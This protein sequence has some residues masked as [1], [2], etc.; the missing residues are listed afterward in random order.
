[1]KRSAEAEHQAAA[2]EPQVWIE[3]CDLFGQPVGEQ[4]QPAGLEEISGSAEPAAPSNESDLFTYVPPAPPAM[5]AIRAAVEPENIG[6]IDLFG[7]VVEEDAP[8]RQASGA[9]DAGKTAPPP[10]GPDLFDFANRAPEPATAEAQPLDSDDFF[11]SV[12][13]Q[14]EEIQLPQTLHEALP[15]Q[16]AAEEAFEPAATPQTA[17]RSPQAEAAEDALRA[18]LPQLDEASKPAA[19]TSLLRSTSWL[20]HLLPRLTPIYS[21]IYKNLA[22]VI[23]GALFTAFVS[24]GVMITFFLTSN[25]WSA[26]IT[27]SRGHELVTKVERELSD[28]NVRKNQISEQ[29]EDAEKNLKSAAG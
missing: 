8:D 11:A 14:L 16:N 4:D 27:L 29:A 3:G 12:R 13:S 17:L 21:L 5:D 7:F 6:K 22:L 20:A 15:A 1:M 2:P 23:L 18:S 24:F 10:G 26:P 9:E 28:L 19:K 25:K